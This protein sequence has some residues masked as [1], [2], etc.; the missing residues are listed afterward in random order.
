MVAAGFTGG[1]AEELRRAMGFKR[2][3]DRMRAIE[4]RLRSGMTERGIVGAAQDEVVRGITS[5]A[6]YGFPE[7][8]SASFA[9]IAYASAYLRAHHP[10]AFLAGLL[11]AWPMGFY[12]PATLVKDAER[13]G[14]R[15]LP[16]DVST[17]EWG[18][19]LER[20]VAER[21]HRREASSAPAP[22]PPRAHG[23]DGPPHGAGSRANVEDESHVRRVERD[24][25]MALLLDALGD[26]RVA[27]LGEE[28]ERDGAHGGDDAQGVIEAEA[29][30]DLGVRLGLR[31]VRGLSAETGARI[32][33]ERAAEP[34][35][36]LADFAKRAAPKRDEIEAL[37][38]SG[39]LASLDARASERRAALWQVTGLERDRRSLFAGVAPPD[40][41]R[42]A[43]LAPLS[44]LET[45][46]ADYR[47]TGLTT[48]PHVMT[49]L[50]A[51]LRARGVLATRELRAVPNGKLVRTAGHVIV[52]QRPGSAKGFCFVT[53]EDET[54]T[55]NGVFTPDQFERWR[56]PLHA[57][58]LIEIA[59]PIQNVDGV[60]HVRVREVVALQGA[61][62]VPES[63]DYH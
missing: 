29:R 32:V 3:V 39:A 21:A 59:G 4:A 49:H 46:L 7:S 62:A 60:I 10:A 51:Q 11:N 57:S 50:R 47:T 2:S 61:E 28:V 31:F 13:H 24:V 33:A 20:V 9:L 17:S 1:E 35:A 55:T 40:A 12:S 8:H 53:L 45:T 27:G 26:E 5:F 36:S 44:P 14:V 30:G 56:G 38:E 18:C 41:A 6:L 54:G 63:H 58:P 52:R 34:F 42:E 43:P 48:G 19:G 15:V 23:E 22:A 16:I 37:A 25:P